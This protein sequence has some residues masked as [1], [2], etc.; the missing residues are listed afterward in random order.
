MHIPD[1]MLPKHIISDRALFARIF[2]SCT[3][4]HSTAF[5]RNRPVE[6]GVKY[7][8]KISPLIRGFPRILFPL[9]ARQNRILVRHINGHLLGSLLDA[10]PGIMAVT[11]AAIDRSPVLSG[12]LCYAVPACIFSGYGS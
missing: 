3:F 12:Q 9:G 8:V 4:S 5:V 1:N 7:P 11:L 6:E 10:P 2:G